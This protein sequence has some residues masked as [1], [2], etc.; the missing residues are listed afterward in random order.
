MWLCYSS[1][2]STLFQ[3]LSEIIAV[4]SSIGNWVTAIFVAVCNSGRFKRFKLSMITT[5]RPTYYDVTPLPDEVLAGIGAGSVERIPA[6]HTF[7]RV[8]FKDHCSFSQRRESYSLRLPLCPN[9]TVKGG[10]SW[11]FYKRYLV[12]LRNAQHCFIHDIEV[13]QGFRSRPEQN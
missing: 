7:Q 8:Q 5:I 4:F 1:L 2:R 3:K 9:F 10:M 6:Y 12:S 13:T 11:F